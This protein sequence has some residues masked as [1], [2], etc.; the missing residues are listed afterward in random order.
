MKICIIGLGYVGLPL[1]VK[2]S[3]HYE[4]T[5]FDINDQRVE[6]LKTGIDRTL[7]VES[8]VL[9]GSSVN[10]TSKKSSLKNQNI[11][12]VTVP[13][14]VTARNVPDLGLLKKASQMLGKAIS[15]GAIIVYESTV[16]PGVTEDFC[17]KIIESSSGLKCG[18]DFFLGYS[19]ERIN[20]GDKLHTVDKIT[21]VVAGQTPEVSEKLKEI[22]SKVTKIFIAKNIKTAEAAKVIE[23]TQRDINIAFMN[24]LTEIFHHDQISIYDVLEAAQTKWNFLPFT[25]GLVGGH[26][27]GVDPYYLAA[28]AKKRGVNPRMTLAGRYI[29]DHMSAF[30]AEL[31]HTALQKKKSNII[32]FGLT[33]K[34]NVPDL[35]NTK[36]A[37][38]IKELEKLGHIIDVVDPV[39]DPKEAYQFYGINLKS[40]EELPQ[41][42]YD[43]LIGAVSHAEF[44]SFSSSF[45][46]GLGKKQAH[47]LDI[48][49]IWSHL[50]LPSYQAISL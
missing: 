30:L 37:A 41:N 15:K 23:N 19:P 21:K 13:T 8:S 3:K 45:L 17:G 42:H 34:E 47:L 35:R 25:P 28:Y 43:C 32:I 46:A 12:I 31:C 1:A 20:P 4:V 26:C 11:Y 14:P 44:V 7:E 39:A 33:F 40:V 29:N 16:Y 24:E 2:L 50:D 22:Y 36:T 6:E 27:I 5:G 49:N 18:T 38:L 10:F 9:Q 48:K